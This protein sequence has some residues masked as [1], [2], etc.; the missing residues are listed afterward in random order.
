MFFI[1]WGFIWEV[2]AICCESFFNCFNIVWDFIWEV[3]AICCE[4]FF[5]CFNIV[6]GGMGCLVLL[7]CLCCCWFF[8]CHISTRHYLNAPI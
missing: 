6:G 7:L 2:V 1:V 3:V 8:F 4:S 5:N